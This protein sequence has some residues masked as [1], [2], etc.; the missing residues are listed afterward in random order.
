MSPQ[1]WFIIVG[2]LGGAAVGLTLAFQGWLREARDEASIREFD[3]WDRLF[4]GDLRRENLRLRK[5]IPS[6]RLAEPPQKPTNTFARVAVIDHSKHEVTIDG[7]RIPW[8][9]TETPEATTEHEGIPV[10]TV[11]LGVLVDGQVTVI[12]EDGKTNSIDPE[13]GNVREFARRLVREGFLE[14][15]P[16]L[17]L[18]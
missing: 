18:P 17:V 7:V 1:D 9:L 12:L 3:R 14:V 2:A 11:N 4:G 6:H 13:L 5:L 8:Y 10:I 15:Y 16:D